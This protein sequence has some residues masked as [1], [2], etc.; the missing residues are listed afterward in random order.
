MSAVGGARGRR[1][2]RRTTGGLV[3][4]LLAVT[5]LVSSAGRVG[6]AQANGQLCGPA[7]GTS[8]SLKVTG[9]VNE[10]RTYDKAALDAMAQTT[11]ADSFLA[12][13]GTTQAN[14]TGVDLA[15]LLELPT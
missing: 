13:A 14:Y 8:D 10:D 4:L 11:V 2:T 12:G 5:G 15:T 1:M 7:G 3:A 9:W 6:A